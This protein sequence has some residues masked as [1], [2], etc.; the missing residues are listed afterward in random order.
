MPV[1]PNT[2]CR[3]SFPRIAG[4]TLEESHFCTLSGNGADHCS[5]DSGGPLQYISQQ[6]QFYQFGIVLF[7]VN[8]YGVY[9]E[10]P[11]FMDWIRSKFV[12]LRNINTRFIFLKLTHRI[13]I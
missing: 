3:A 7:G 2:H 4:F 9:T 12:T 11:H 13:I 5:G 1:Y 6:N 10:V 8:S